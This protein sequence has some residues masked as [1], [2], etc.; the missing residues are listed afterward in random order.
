MRSLIFGNCLN[1]LK[2]EQLRRCIYGC[3]KGVSIAR[4]RRNFSTSTKKQQKI[5]ITGSLGQLGFGIAKELR[6]KYGDENI[7]M[8][9]VVKAPSDISNSGPFLYADIL[10][11]KNLQSIVVNYN[12]D[13]IVHLS[14]LLSAIGE[15]NVS[16]ALKINIYGF[17]NII[18]LCRRYG[19]KLFCP[20]TIGAFGPDSP[21]NPTPDLTIQRP[22]TIYGVSKVHMELMGEY[23][24]HRYGLDFRS[25]RYPGVISAFTQPGGGTTDYAVDIFH[26]ALKTGKFEC[27]LTENTRLPMMY[28]DDVIKATADMIDTPKEELKIRTY[29]IS[30]MSFTPKEISEEVKKIMPEFEISYDV[31]SVRQKI[32]ESWPQVFDDQ[33]AR[34]DWG[35]QHDFDLTKMC[36]E[37]FRLL[38]PGYGKDLIQ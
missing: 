28:I 5:L 6:R 19:L 37:M 16:E 2:Q 26:C 20:S 7:V 15:H 36:K 23:Y 35:W 1:Q 29:N 33:N 38:G 18:E 11:Y 8:S 9:D 21:R 12:I 14:A 25:L 17:H 24:H 4:E 34:K 27:N 32:A 13:T 31:D 22:R 3:A 10:D 30:A